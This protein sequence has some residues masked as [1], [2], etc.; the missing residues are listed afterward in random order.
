MYMTYKIVREHNL[1]VEYYEG[2]IGIHDI[3]ANKTKLSKEADFRSTDNMI[4]DLRHANVQM[5]KNGLQKIV[6]F[7]KS[8]K[9]FQDERKVVYLTSKPGEVV[10]TI[11]FSKEVEEY[12]M[13][14][15]TVSTFEAA[16]LF[17]SIDGLEKLQLNNIIEELKESNNTSQ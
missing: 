16:I 7:Y 17:L 2:D 11:L 10:N 5:D 6:A 1:V 9:V 12:R 15:Q 8:Q 4:L 13:R 14:P 3:I